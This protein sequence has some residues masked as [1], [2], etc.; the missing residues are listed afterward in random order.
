VHPHKLSFPNAKI[1]L[2]LHFFLTLKYQSFFLDILFLPQICVPELER[3]FVHWMLR[4]DRF[5]LILIPYEHFSYIFLDF[6]NS[7]VKDWCRIFVLL[8]ETQ[9]MQFISC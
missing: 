4:E 9:R 5:D 6:A 3:N 2:L 7:E 1:I 8:H